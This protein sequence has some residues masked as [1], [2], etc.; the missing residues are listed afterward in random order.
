MDFDG[1]YYR[2][3][4]SVAQNENG[5]FVY[6]IGKIEERS[7]PTIYGSSAEGGA[8]GGKTSFKGS[9]PHEHNAVKE[10]FSY[11]GK[12]AESGLMKMVGS[13][14][15]LT[16]KTDAAIFMKLPSISRTA[17][18]EGSCTTSTMFA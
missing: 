4:I 11:A 2:V 7:L 10:R 5:N 13:T 1:K 6:N 18:N 17:E 15:K 3:Q 8:L 9:V 14:E 12:N 16:F